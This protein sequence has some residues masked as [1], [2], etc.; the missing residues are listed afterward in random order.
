MERLE[1]YRVLNVREKPS[2]VL[3]GGV[4]GHE[5]DVRCKFRVSLALNL[6]DVFTVHAGHP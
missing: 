4:P 3:A 5:D 6:E 1:E 2:R